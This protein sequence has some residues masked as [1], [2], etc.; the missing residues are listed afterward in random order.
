MLSSVLNLYKKIGETPLAR[1][2]RFRSNN[3]EYGESKMSYAGRLDPMAEGVLVVL[4]GEEN[5]KREK[6]L[7]LTKEYTAEILFGIKTDTH[8]I[9]GKIV[10][11]HHVGEPV[12]KMQG[13]LKKC[14]AQFIG[15][16]HQKY[17]AYSSKTVEGKPLF[18]WAKEGRISEIKIPKR[19][20]E[21]YSIHISTY[22]ALSQHDLL[23]DIEGRVRLV[24]GDFRQSEILTLWKECLRDNKYGTFGVATITVSCSSG[25][26]IRVLAHELGRCLKTGAL[27]L[28]LKRDCVG[29]YSIRNSIP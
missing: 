16:Q 2:E 17:P 21:I 29:T 18:V 6:Y 27:L 12:K 3:S 23:S 28:S 26:Y 19:E 4:V 22:D 5:K 7:N 8:D 10:E 13:S 11:T 25:T 1:I 9:L 14:T 24:Q 20:I 15:V